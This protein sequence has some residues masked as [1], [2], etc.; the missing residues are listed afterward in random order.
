MKITL[1]QPYV[2]FCDNRVV[3]HSIV[4]AMNRR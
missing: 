1:V 2:T 4:I 3:E